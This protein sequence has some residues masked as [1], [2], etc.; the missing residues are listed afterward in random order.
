MLYVLYGISLAVQIS[1]H[2][3]HA[4]GHRTKRSPNRKNEMFLKISLV[5]T[6]FNDQTQ[7]RNVMTCIIRTRLKQHSIYHIVILK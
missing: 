5:D 3:L 4:P 1:Q 6:V 2:A 7:Q